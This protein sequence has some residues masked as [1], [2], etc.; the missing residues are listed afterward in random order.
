MGAPGPASPQMQAKSASR[1]FAGNISLPAAALFSFLK[2]T[3]GVTA[4]TLRDF[5]KTLGLSSSAAAQA[6]AILEMQGY[7][8]HSRL[9]EWMTTPEG[10]TVSGSKF[11]RFS[12]TS[13]EQSLASLANHL[14]RV[15]HDSSA[16]YK[17]ADAV[18]FGDF[19]N[20]RSRVQAADVGIGLS[21]RNSSQ[22][23]GA[24]QPSH[25]RRQQE[26]LKKLRC[27][28]P[29]LNVRP[30]ADWMSLRSHRNLLR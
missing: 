19:L 24:S 22:V 18:A 9:D 25:D 11:P 5:A 15:N 3:R 17:I 28:T 21:T 7:V 14:K 29:L 12:R 6:L 2:D 10:E 27:R 1:A 13:V 8:H 23:S 16:P 30:Y 4:W 20:E 26:F